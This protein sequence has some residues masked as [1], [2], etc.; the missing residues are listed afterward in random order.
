MT[1]SIDLLLKDLEQL[2][3]EHPELFAQVLAMGV[4]NER[5]RVGAWMKFVDADAKAVADGISS[6][7]ALTQTAMADFTMKIITASKLGDLSAEG[8][9]IKTETEKVEGEK[10]ELTAAEN[11]KAQVMGGLGLKS[12]NK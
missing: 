4:T 6:G 1:K 3:A 9:V 11:L 8:A 12:E 10:E 5:D 7:E 2:K